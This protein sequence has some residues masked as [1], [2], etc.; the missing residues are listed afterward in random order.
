METGLELRGKGTTEMTALD[1]VDLT[2]ALRTKSL[3]NLLRN[4]G[5]ALGSM[6]LFL[7]IADRRLLVVVA[8]VLAASAAGSRSSAGLSPGLASRWAACIWA[9]CSSWRTTAGEPR[10]L[11]AS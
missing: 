7:T 8:V 9:L 11:G 3:L 1:S 5:V 4:L 2:S 6:L 10:S